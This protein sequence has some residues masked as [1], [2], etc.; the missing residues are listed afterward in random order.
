MRSSDSRMSATSAWR[1]TIRFIRPSPD[2]HASAVPRGAA[3]A[4]DHTG[5]RRPLAA[6]TG[7]MATT[8]S[9]DEGRIQGFRD[10]LAV[11]GGC[12]RFPPLP[13]PGFD[14]HWRRGGGG[15]GGGGHR[16]RGLHVPRAVPHGAAG[17]R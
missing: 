11:R 1:S 13:P 17:P 14:L 4:A 5:G 3:L 10:L 7:S 15:G 16:A 6:V 2:G 8:P 9:T 12:R